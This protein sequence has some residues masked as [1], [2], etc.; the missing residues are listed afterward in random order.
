MSN[1]FGVAY[2]M[3]AEESA[4]ARSMANIIIQPANVALE[5]SMIPI[6]NTAVAE[7]GTALQATKAGALPAE[8]GFN[9]LRFG[10]IVS[11]GSMLARGALYVG[12]PLLIAGA[13]A[14]MV[15]EYYNNDANNIYIPKVDDTLSQNQ[16]M[17]Y[18]KLGMEVTPAQPPDVGA[19]P[20][21]DVSDYNT[22]LDFLAD[23]ASLSYRQT[24]A[25]GYLD[26]LAARLANVASGIKGSTQPKPDFS[27]LVNDFALAMKNDAKFLKDGDIPAPVQ[28]QAQQQI[29]DQK[30]ANDA[31]VDLSKNGITLNPP[32][33]ANGDPSCI[34]VK[35]CQETILALA[36]ETFGSKFLAPSVPVNTGLDLSS[37]NFDLTNDLNVKVKEL[38]SID[39]NQTFFNTLGYFMQTFKPVNAQELQN[40]INSIELLKKQDLQDLFN[41]NL[42]D[43][44]NK[45]IFIDTRDTL[46]NAFFYQN[47]SLFKWLFDA[48]NNINSVFDFAFYDK[49]TK[50]FNRF[51]VNRKKDNNIIDFHITEFEVNNS[52]SSDSI[53]NYKN[54]CETFKDITIFEDGQYYDILG[55]IEDV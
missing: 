6:G 47:I 39:L 32:R 43:S 15:N 34:P 19:R 53:L 48:L 1:I 26:Q 37:L 2:A 29:D 49:I 36:L 4:L 28:Q 18:V 11:G 13:V 38:P 46:K 12:A 41:T 16:T 23:D 44:Q 3:T 5:Q 14:Y 7:V 55:Q 50:V 25:Q 33:N 54:V 10:Q 22:S 40:I 8:L 9:G 45:N 30:K 31:L 17:V 35:L 20:I 21:N 24:L 27:P 42:K 51:F 52:I